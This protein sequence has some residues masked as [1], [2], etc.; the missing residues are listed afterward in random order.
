MCDVNSILHLGITSTI[1]TDKAIQNLCSEE[2]LLG[3]RSDK[4]KYLMSVLLVY[5]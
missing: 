2:G 5:Y 1:M 4:W 3:I